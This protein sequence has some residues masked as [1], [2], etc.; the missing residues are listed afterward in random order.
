MSDTLAEHWDGSAW[1]IVPTPSP[2]TG[3]AF[4]NEGLSFSSDDT[5]V[6]GDYDNSTPHEGTGNSLIEHWNGTG[7]SVVPSPNPGSSGNVLR[8]IDGVSPTDIWAN[9]FQKNGSEDSTLIVHYDGTSWSQVASPNVGTGKN[10][11]SGVAAI[12]S[13][14][15]WS[16]GSYFVSGGVYRTLAMHWDGE[17][18]NVVQTPSPGKGTKYP[19]GALLRIAWGTSSSDVWAVGRYWNGTAFRNL[20]LHWNGTAWVRVATPNF[21]TG[22]NELRRVHGTGSND[23]WA[24]GYYHDTNVNKDRALALHW[25]GTAWSKSPIKSANGSS[26]LK[27]LIA[28][29]GTNVWAAGYKASSGGLFRSLIERWN[30]TSWIIISSP[31]A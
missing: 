13:D 17:T 9:G 10:Y 30:G 7:W 8:G 31:N 21:G 11:L 29:S 2:G 15:V 27:G 28:F 26:Y 12:S 25:D 6:V 23:V 24:V 14:D 1:S 3:S 22:D 4:L 5:W 16:V 20:A 18:W 19:Q